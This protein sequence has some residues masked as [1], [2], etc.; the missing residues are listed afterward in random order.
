ME[1]IWKPINLVDKEID[2]GDY[3]EVSNM[4]EMRNR[5]TQ[6]VRSNCRNAEGYNFIVMKHKKMSKWIHIGRAVALTFIP[7][8]SGAGNVDHI[9]RNKDDN[10]VENLRWV[11]A[12]ENNLN[13]EYSSKKRTRKKPV[14]QYDLEG[15]FIKSYESASAAYRETGIHYSSILKVAQGWEHRNTAGGY[16]WRFYHE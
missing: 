11:T 5:R 9:N 16:V 7:N 2:W 12:S 3:Y 1:E 15:N 6:K 14:A 4:G 13:R 8:P 10:R